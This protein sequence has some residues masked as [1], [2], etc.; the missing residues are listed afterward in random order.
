MKAKEVKQA[1]FEMLQRFLSTGKTE[2]CHRDYTASIVEGYVLVS[3]MKS[4]RHEWPT[5]KS[6]EIKI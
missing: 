5:H 2:F 4:K 6:F 1:A 3:Y